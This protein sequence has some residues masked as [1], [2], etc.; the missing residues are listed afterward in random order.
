MLFRSGRYA[1]EMTFKVNVEMTD[2]FEP[3]LRPNQFV[4]YTK[5]TKVVKKAASITKK[6]KNDLA[7][8]KK[9]YNYVIKNYKY[10]KKLAKTVKPG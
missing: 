5:S 10:D 2:Q 9:V 1:M 7:K 4:N 6:C 8:V 3:Y